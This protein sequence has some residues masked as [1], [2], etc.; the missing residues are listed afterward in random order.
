MTGACE[1]GVPACGSTDNVHPYLTGLACPLHTPAAA[2]GR[3]EVV[4][5]PEWGSEAGYAKS[6]WH[7]SFNRNDTALIDNRARASGKRASGAMRRAN[8]AE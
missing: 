8:H 2:A 7:R 3:E 1:Q 6:G 5:D 4:P